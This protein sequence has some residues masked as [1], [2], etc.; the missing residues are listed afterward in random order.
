MISLKGKNVFLTGATG[1]IGKQLEDLLIKE[2]CSVF[3]IGSK[4]ADYTKDG[5]IYN[6]IIKAKE[7]MEHID[8]LINSAGLFKGTFDDVFSVNV[9]APYIFIRKFS[10]EMIERKWGRI[11]NIGSISAY[12]GI[13]GNAIYCAS[14]HALLGLSRAFYKELK[15]HNIRVYCISPAGVKTL[16]GIQCANSKEE[17]KKFLEP[18]EVAEY[19]IFILKFNRELIT[20]EVRLNRYE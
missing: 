17:L 7:R 11:V 9:K 19:I 20:E 8:I 2:G 10:E 4:E 12:R 1:G 14:K 18:K 5:D 15:K 13:E 3:G 16:M 6:I